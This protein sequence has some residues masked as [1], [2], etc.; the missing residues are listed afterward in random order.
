MAESVLSL[1][2]EEDEDVLDFLAR[3]EQL[4]REA[5]GAQPTTPRALRAIIA[6]CDLLIVY[7]L[8][9]DNGRNITETA[10]ALHTS[11]RRVRDQIKAWHRAQGLTVITSKGHGMRFI[12]TPEPTPQKRAARTNADGKPTLD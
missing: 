8:W 10:R 6:D 2:T 1:A 9:I 3:W 4:G 11:R 7:R 12:P 5:I